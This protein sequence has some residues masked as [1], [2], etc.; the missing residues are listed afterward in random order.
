MTI[1]PPVHAPLFLS[2]AGPA[3]KLQTEAA[4]FNF[5]ILSFNSFPIEFTPD[6]AAVLCAF[7]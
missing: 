5:K 3:F 1:N 4:S 7:P 6:S 2:T